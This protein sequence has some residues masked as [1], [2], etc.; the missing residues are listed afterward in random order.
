MDFLQKNITPSMLLAIMVIGFL[1]YFA[2]EIFLHLDK[3]YSQLFTVPA[4]VTFCKTYVDEGYYDAD[5]HET[6][7]VL[8]FLIGSKRYQ[9]VIYKQNATRYEVG[10]LKETDYRKGKYTG[11]IYLA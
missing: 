6:K 10:S 9:K 7:T 8:E 3:K 2:K 1:V 4:E 5:H 11:K